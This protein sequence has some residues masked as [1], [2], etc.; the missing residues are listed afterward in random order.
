MNL[1]LEIQLLGEH[2]PV[3]HTLNGQLC[4]A[5]QGGNTREGSLN[6]IR[7]THAL[8]Y[9]CHRASCG[10]GGY[11]PA[12]EGSDWYMLG[13][14]AYTEKLKKKEDLQLEQLPQE[15]EVHLEQKYG[16][17]KYQLDF[18]GVR[19]HRDSDSV[20]YPVYS[21]SLYL[22]PVGYQLRGPYKKIHTEVFSQ[23]EFK[24]G[25][26][27]CRRGNRQ[28]QN[29]IVLVEDPNSALKVSLILDSFCLFGTHLNYEKIVALVNEKYTGA[30][31]H[32][33]WDARAK[34]LQYQREYGMFFKFL[35]PVFTFKDPKDTGLKELQELYGNVVAGSGHQEPESIF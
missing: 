5:C 32:L 17:P 10:V 27:Y 33:D 18:F 26:F 6:I 4:P 7:L 34:A 20:A 1:S 16:I 11:V 25:G 31:V 3:G 2:L 22:D 12:V 28:H 13:Q 19:Y 15:K 8:A 14:Q 9:K 21:D 24:S 29:V 35:L 23:A 30:L